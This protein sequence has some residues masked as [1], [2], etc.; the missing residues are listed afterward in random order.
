MVEMARPGGVGGRGS[1]ILGGACSPVTE[2]GS[3]PDEQ[4]IAGPCDAPER[5]AQVAPL[6]E[7][8]AGTIIS[9]AAIADGPDLATSEMLYVRVGITPGTTVDRLLI[10]TDGDRLS[11]MWTLQSHL[12]GSGWNYLVDPK[13]G[14]AR[15]SGVPSQ[16]GYEPV[17]AE[18][19]ETLVTDDAYLFC[20]PV[21]GL[22]KRAPQSVALAAENEEMSLPARFLEGVNYPPEPDDGAPDPTTL[23][24]KLGF[25]YSAAPWIVR[26]CRASKATQKSIA[27]AASVYENFDQ[28]V[29]DTDFTTHF[30]DGMGRLVAEI[31]ARRPE[32]EVWGYVSIVG[33]TKGPDGTRTTVFSVAD[34]LD[35]AKRF[36]DA[37]MTGIFLDEYDVCDPNYETC[38]LGPDGRGIEITRQKQIEVVEGLH[39][40]GLAAFANGHSVVDALA[41]LDGLPTPLGTGD[42][43][44]PA[45]QYLLENPTLVGG[46]LIGGTDLVGSMARFAQAI[47]LH[48]Q[49]G[50]RLAV[51][52][53]MAGEISD[54]ALA[55]PLPAFVWWRAAQAGAA[56][57]AARKRGARVEL[58]EPRR[59]RPSSGGGRWL[60]FVLRTRQRSG[61]G[62]DHGAHR[63][64][65]RSRRDRD[66]QG[67]DREIWT[68]C[69][70]RPLNPARSGLL[71]GPRSAS[72]RHRPNCPLMTVSSP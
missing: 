6:V 63:A 62:A 27:C 50:A 5:W 68:G 9:L 48:R 45:D 69:R 39:S 15:H 38:Q 64:R 54:D 43:D 49:T 21:R 3:A 10:D 30:A 26:G 25:N 17:E 12:S 24:G 47:E 55:Q 59:S 31:R 44:R 1:A 2:E 40:M 57:F 65:L 37:G 7:D 58:G 41:E 51:L 33:S 66:P 52:D 28:I 56:V 14:L 60:R 53:S 46:Q 8:P 34:I 67:R 29:L 13:A 22:G 71:R 18:G 42:G 20:I 4:Q 23:P 19:L 61:R 70:L 72:A 16:W 32:I 35:E 11:G 36:Q